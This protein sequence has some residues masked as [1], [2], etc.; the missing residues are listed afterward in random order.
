MARSRDPEGFAVLNDQC[1]RLAVGDAARQIALARIAM[2]MAAKG[3]RAADITVG[4]CIQMVQIAAE[5][6]KASGK[7]RGTAARSSISW[8]VPWAGSPTT[9]RPAP[10]RSTSPAR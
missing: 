10:E 3:G 2:I 1:Q 5:A 6:T 8:C 7:T 9:H 4:D